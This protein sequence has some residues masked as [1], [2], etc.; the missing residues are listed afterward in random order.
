MYFASLIVLSLLKKI[1][2]KIQDTRNNCRD[3][4][5]DYYEESS[6]VSCDHDYA[7]Y[8]DSHAI[9]EAAE[10]EPRFE[11]F[12]NR[13]PLVCDDVFETFNISGTKPIFGSSWSRYREFF[14]SA[15]WN[16]VG[17][18]CKPCGVSCRG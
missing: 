10:K 9:I 4:N 11:P 13:T 16:G 2:N 17:S 3:T 8:Y 6:D 15:Y 18:I 1:L 7:F 14:H 5:Y 12:L